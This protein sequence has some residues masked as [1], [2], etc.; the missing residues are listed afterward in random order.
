MVKQF[1]PAVTAGMNYVTVWV[2]LVRPFD[3][4]A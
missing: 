1:G 3:R 2:V 4:T